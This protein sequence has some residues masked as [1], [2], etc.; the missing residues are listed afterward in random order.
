[1][2]KKINLEMTSVENREMRLGTIIAWDGS[3][4]ELVEKSNYD[5]RRQKKQGILPKE[6]EKTGCAGDGG[7]ACR[8]C[9][10]HTPL[11]QQTMCA[12]SIVECQI[13]NLTDCIL[14]QHSPIGCA[15][16]NSHFNLAFKMGLT[17]RHKPKQNLRIFCTNLLEKDMVFGASDKLRQAIREAKERFSP[18]AIFISM[19]CATAIIGEDIDRIASELEPEIGVPIIPLHCEGFRSKHWSTGFD[20][21][22]HGVAQKIVKRN[23]QKQKDLINIVALWGTDYFTDILKPLGLRVNYM[24]DCASYDELAQAS[25]AVATTTFCHTLGSYM[26]TILEQ[27]FGVPQID[28]P[29]PYGI[30]GTDEWLR[31][32]GKVVGKEEETEAYIQA[33]HERVLPK[34]QA[35]REKFKGVKG[36]IM[37]GSAYAHGLISVLRELGIEVQGSVVFHHDPVYDGGAEHQNTLKSLIDNYGDIKHYTVSKTQA[38][39]LPQ[40]LRRVETDFVI[41]RHQGLAPEAAK[42]GI[43]A[44]AMGDEHIPVGY[45]G[46][47]RTGEILLDIL[48]RKRFNKVLQRHVKLPYTDWWQSQND[49][50]IL[51]TNPDIIDEVLHSGSKNG[52]DEV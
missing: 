40:V 23:P 1:M 28:A 25:E 27:H 12:N 35:L 10:L 52:K 41:I 42:L 3:A 13:G 49:P 8:L 24:L 7:K 45:D 38:Y 9:E 39:Q 16:D 15:A 2:A 17:R 36:F 20:I 50:F 18:R 32:I 46:I 31:A 43:P 30:V 51:S 14:I 37:T 29:Q 21:S 26:A 44:L 11:G 19:A 4:K 33:E 48:A 5:T 6:G 47:V 34:I 22:Q